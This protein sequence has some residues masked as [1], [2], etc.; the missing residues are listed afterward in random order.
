M[1]Q[2]REGYLE[3]LKYLNKAPGYLYTFFPED[4]KTMQ[5]VEKVCMTMLMREGQMNLLTGY[6]EAM[7]MV[8][9]FILHYEPLPLKTNS[10]RN[11]WPGA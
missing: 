11:I 9:Q 8:Y 4:W 7:K 3:T 1:P 2:M 5:R 10:A 6:K